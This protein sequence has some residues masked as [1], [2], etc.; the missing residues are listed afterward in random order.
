MYSLGY[1]T[2]NQGKTSRFGYCDDVFFTSCNEI[3]NAQCVFLK[4]EGLA[5]VMHKQPI[6]PLDMTKL[7]QSAIF[8]CK[9]PKSLRPKVF[10]N[11]LFFLCRRGQENLRELKKSNFLLKVD[12]N[13]C[14]FIEKCTD[15]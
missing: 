2:K 12:E 9:T 1:S 4:K 11:V 7:Y 3:F 10:F 15:K 8:D 6:S 13:D 14:E 5:K